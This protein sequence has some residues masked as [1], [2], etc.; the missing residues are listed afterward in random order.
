MRFCAK[1]TD[2]SLE[3]LMYGKGEMLS[4]TTAAEA[5][6]NRPKTIDLGSASTNIIV[7]TKG[8]PYYNVDFQL[9]FDPVMI[10]NR[11]NADAMFDIE[12]YNHCSC[13]CFARGDSM[14][15]TIS[16]GDYVALKRVD[17][18]SYLINNEIYAI[19]TKND[20]RTI[21]RV[22]DNGD[23]ITLIPDNKNY[24]EQTIPKS[25]ITHVFVVKAALKPF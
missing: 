9:G 22:K 18:L 24:D 23:T 1:F 5:I 20:L 25:I 7:G 13:W 14:Q 15:P 10:D 4:K 3:W 21:K 6:F 16:S 8:V 12:P 2:F 11:T 17:D 19:I